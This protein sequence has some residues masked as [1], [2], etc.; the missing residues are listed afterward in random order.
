MNR[1]GILPTAASTAPPIM[2]HM[3]LSVGEPVNARL[4]LD[5]HAPDMLIPQTCFT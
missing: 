4:T 2:A 3:A 5:S 1:R